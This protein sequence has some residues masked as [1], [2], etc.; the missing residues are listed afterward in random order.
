MPKNKFI[1]STLLITS[2]LFFTTIVSNRVAVGGCSW[3]DGLSIVRLFNSGRHTTWT[4]GAGR[5]RCASHTGV[6]RAANVPEPVGRPGVKSALGR[7]TC[8]SAYD[9]DCDCHPQ[10]CP[11]YDVG[12]S[13]SGR[14]PGA[15]CS[16][17]Y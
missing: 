1:F 4:W 10:G 7:D 16:G 2:A 6:G 15:G 12:A 17:P 8:S 5:A 3:M 11:P 14:A 9:I 13:V